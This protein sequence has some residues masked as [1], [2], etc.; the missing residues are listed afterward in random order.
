VAEEYTP[1][2]KIV[3]QLY[4]NSMDPA[5][6]DRWLAE[7]RREAAEKGWDEVADYHDRTNAPD[8]AESVRRDNP[9]RKE[10]P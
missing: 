8:F 3:R 7:V 5:G 2:T 9:Y 1:T 10:Q 6:F 4:A